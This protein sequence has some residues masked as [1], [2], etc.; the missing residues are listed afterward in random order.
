MTPSASAADPATWPIVALPI[1]SPWP[2]ARVG[3]DGTVV[4]FG[5]LPA[6]LNA[7]VRFDPTGRLW[8]LDPT[9][10]TVTGYALDGDDVRELV[11][12]PLPTHFKAMDLAVD[13]RHLYLG[14][15]APWGIPEIDESLR[16][17]RAGLPATDGYDQPK[18]WF[19]G[20]LD[21]PGWMALALPAL[22]GWVRHCLSNKAIDA[23]V[24]DGDHLVAVDDVVLPKWFFRFDRTVEGAPSLVGSVD[25]SHRPNE[26]TV[27]GAARSSQWI[28]LRSEGT[29]RSGNFRVVRVYAR[30]S[31]EARAILEQRFDRARDS[32]V[33]D[34]WGG[35]AFVGE[36]L[37]V[38]AH[39]D[40]LLDIDC[41]RLDPPPARARPIDL[42]RR[43]SRVT[44]AGATAVLDVVPVEAWGGALIVVAEGDRRRA[45]WYP[46][47]GRRD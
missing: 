6:P 24:I 3:P 29:N 41:S 45:D 22:S 28:A 15:K 38:A 23:L 7:L 35:A 9:A 25:L 10:A 18:L 12:H 2:I 33:N 16:R 1:S 47:G 27:P 19:R 36:R 20:A 44:V 46:V 39:A 43:T 37:L 5:A 21:G 4:P 30:G 8:S 31:L 14:G 42:A 34:P 26:Q 32:P 40:G 11:A 13:E 17:H